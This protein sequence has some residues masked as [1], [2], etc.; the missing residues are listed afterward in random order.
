MAVAGGLKASPT[1]ALRTSSLHDVALDG[2]DADALG[3]D[4]VQPPLD[5][6]HV[7]LQLQHHP[8]AVL[9][10]VGAADVGHDAELFA[11]LI[12]D[13]NRDQLLREGELDSLSGHPYLL[14]LPAGKRPYDALPAV[15][16]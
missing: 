13:R 8:A 3:G 7:A 15:R 16:E 9:R 4:P 1:F 11:Q 6:L 10:H 12:D 5:L 2:V 14:L